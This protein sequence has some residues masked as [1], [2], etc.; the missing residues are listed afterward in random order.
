M[1]EVHRLFS[2]D[3]FQDLLLYSSLLRF[4]WQ[5]RQMCS[6]TGGAASWGF[7][8]SV[9][10]HAVHSFLVCLFARLSCLASAL[11]SN[12]SVLVHVS[13]LHVQRAH[14]P[15][16]SF[17]PLLLDRVVSALLAS[18]FPQTPHADPH[19]LHQ[20]EELREPR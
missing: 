13:L 6:S 10:L 20:A 15:H 9:S 8:L 7:C 18:R 12:V 5:P 2:R 19:W 4:L 3:L 11:S 17:K 14:G 1:H 16:T